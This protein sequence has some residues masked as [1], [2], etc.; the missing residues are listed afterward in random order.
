MVKKKAEL[1]T[2]DDRLFKK[3][4]ELATWDYRLFKKKAEFTTKT[5]RIINREAPLGLGD[6]L[7]VSQKQLETDLNG[8]LH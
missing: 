8:P 4:A 2:Q 7:P 6:C 5:S 3:K 1:A